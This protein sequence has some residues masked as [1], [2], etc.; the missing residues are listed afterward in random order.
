MSQLQQFIQISRQTQWL[1]VIHLPLSV[2]F[3]RHAGSKLLLQVLTQSLSIAA[4]PALSRDIGVS[5]SQNLIDVTTQSGGFAKQQIFTPS[6]PHISVTLNLTA[7]SI[8]AF[9][10]PVLFDISV[11]GRVMTPSRDIF[12]PPL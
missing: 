4:K 11:T 8:Q 12:M 3:P 1:T 5:G 2:I 6:F 10:F 9:P 7:T